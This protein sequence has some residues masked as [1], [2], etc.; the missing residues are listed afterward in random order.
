MPGF[1]DEIRATR[2]A[3][4]YTW[5]TS[6]T[7]GVLGP[8]D[9][10]NTGQCFTD[11]PVVFTRIASPML[12]KI[13]SDKEPST[14][15]SVTGVVHVAP[16]A[17]RTKAMAAYRPFQVLGVLYTPTEQSSVVV[18]DEI[19]TSAAEMLKLP[20]PLPMLGYAEIIDDTP[21]AQ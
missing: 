14:R 2:A 4:I 21:A 11:I 5:G 18:L 9:A 6:A 12:A 16:V 7:L 20:P 10:P 13:V 3:L 17:A 15:R 19:R 8:H 1:L